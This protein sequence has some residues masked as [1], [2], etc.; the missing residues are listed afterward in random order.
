MPALAAYPLAALAEIAGCFAICTWWRLGATPFWI[1]PG[2][3]ALLAFGWL[4]AITVSPSQ[5]RR[6][7]PRAVLCPD[8]CDRGP[9]PQSTSKWTQSPSRP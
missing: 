2:G 7:C 4:P 8:R 6:V 9:E 5:E 1:L 3:C